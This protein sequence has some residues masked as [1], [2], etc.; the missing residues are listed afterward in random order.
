M[1]KIKVENGYN[2]FSPRY[3]SPFKYKDKNFFNVYQF[4]LYCQT[5][6]AGLKQE[7]IEILN[8]RNNQKLYELDKYNKKGLKGFRD[9]FKKGKLSENLSEYLKVGMREKYRQNPELMK[10]LM[11]VDIKD[12]NFKEGIFNSDINKAF[13]EGLQKAV[14]QI[15]VEQELSL[16]NDKY[17]NNTKTISKSKKLK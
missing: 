2:L 4:M 8:T 9:N 12:I 17:N 3:K 6:N 13:K 5:N 10:E 16:M 7:A 11:N 14:E 1:L 15:K